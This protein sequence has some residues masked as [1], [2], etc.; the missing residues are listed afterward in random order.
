[1]QHLSEKK[2]CCNWVLP[3]MYFVILTESQLWLVSI[4]YLTDERFLWLGCTYTVTNRLTYARATRF[5][6]HKWSHQNTSYVCTLKSWINVIIAVV[7][8]SKYISL[9]SAIIGWNLGQKQHILT[10]T[11]CDGPQSNRGRVKKKVQKIF[12]NCFQLVW[13]A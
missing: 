2:S 6:Q 3:S 11:N 12:F 10:L 7:Y 8:L 5:F 1:M 13:F 4:R 9:L